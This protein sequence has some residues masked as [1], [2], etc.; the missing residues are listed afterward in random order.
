[1]IAE[2][3]ITKIIQMVTDIHD[4]LGMEIPRDQELEDMKQSTHVEKLADAID[5]AEQES[6]PEAAKGP[7]SAADTEG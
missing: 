2:R 5:A 3:E 7:E 4:H 1:M 6:D